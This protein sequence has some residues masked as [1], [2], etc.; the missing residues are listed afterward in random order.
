MPG[1][2]LFDPFRVACWAKEIRIS[3]KRRIVETHGRASKKQAKNKK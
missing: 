2:F 3:I 1:L